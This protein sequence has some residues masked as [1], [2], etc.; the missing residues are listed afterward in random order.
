MDD[1]LPA[2]D[3]VLA[4]CA[5]PDDEAF[6]LGAL[7]STL[8]DAGS[9]ITVLCYTRGEASTVSRSSGS[10]STSAYSMYSFISAAPGPGVGRA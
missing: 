1:T 10:A 6:G 8:A 5:H 4:V 2:F 9:R 7:L 3:S